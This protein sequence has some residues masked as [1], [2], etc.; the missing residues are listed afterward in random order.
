MQVGDSLPFALGVNSSTRINVAII[1]PIVLLPFFFVR[2][3]YL[4]GGGI[5]FLGVKHD[6]VPMRDRISFHKT[7]VSIYESNNHSIKR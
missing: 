6:A 3:V 7:V 5:V 2:D 4:L 1:Q